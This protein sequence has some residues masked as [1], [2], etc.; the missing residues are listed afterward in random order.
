MRTTTLTPVYWDPSG[1]PTYPTF[2]QSQLDQFL[3][4]VAS[5]SGTTG[6]FF[7]TLPQY[8]DSI[9][10]RTTTSNTP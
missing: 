10:D 4:D 2:Y 7:S 3:S 1:G 9:G 6:N 5:A 8:Y